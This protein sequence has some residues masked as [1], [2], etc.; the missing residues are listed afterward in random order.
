LYAALRELNDIGVKILTV[1]DPV[2]YDIEGI[3]QMQAREEIDVGFAN[4]MRHFLRQ[5]PDI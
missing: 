5:D 2:E 4:A 3:M 1:E